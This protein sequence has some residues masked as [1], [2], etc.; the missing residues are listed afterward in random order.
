MG[1]SGMDQISLWR[2]Q[3][4][5]NVLQGVY[6]M[7]WRCNT[8]PLQKEVNT[9]L[10]CFEHSIHFCWI[11]ES[12]IVLRA[13]L[14]DSSYLSIL[15]MQQLRLM[16]LN[17]P[18]ESVQWRWGEKWSPGHPDSETMPCLVSSTWM[19]NSVERALQDSRLRVGKFSGRTAA[20]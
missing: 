20:L 19:M 2:F 4:G 7:L 6:F 14:Q 12:E 5:P 17:N 18:S 11:N 15:Q 9:R 13:T 16:G 10:V 3:T 8:I 1:W